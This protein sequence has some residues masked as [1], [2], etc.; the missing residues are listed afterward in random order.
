[1]LFWRKLLFYLFVAAYLVVCPLLILYT[2]G[3]SLRPGGE[4]TIVRTGMIYVSSIPVG[5]ELYL[6]GRL[7]PDRTP[8]A[9]RNLTPGTYEVRVAAPGY[10]SW[11]TRVTLRAN[12]VRWFNRVL[13]LPEVWSAVKRSEA[14]FQDLIPAEDAPFCI[15]KRGGTVGDYRIYLMQRDQLLPLSAAGTAL[16]DAEVRKVYTVDRSRSFLLE[17][18]GAGKPRVL[19]ASIHAEAVRLEDITAL[20]PA[21]FARVDWDPHDDSVLFPV[22]GKTIGMVDLE[23]RSTL[24][25]FVRQAQGAGVFERHLYVLST[26]RLLYRLAYP[27]GTRQPVADVPATGLTGTDQFYRIR[28]LAHRQVCLLGAQGQF[29]ALLPPDHA[30]LTGVR[31]FTWEPLRGRM[32]VWTR[33]RVG[34]LEFVPASRRASGEPPT[35]LRWVYSGGADVAQAFWVFRFS[36]VLVRDGTSLWLVPLGEEDPSPS[37]LVTCKKGTGVQYDRSTGTL[38]YIGATGALMSLE[39]V[40]RSELLKLSILE[41]RNEL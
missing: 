41:I 37:P 12:Q 1:M 39:I 15:L 8:T 33:E 11:S 20:L 13:L 32:L 27:D 40:P 17:V 29:L 6:Q 35:R 18:A 30:A 3:I 25:V 38:F 7:Q 24:P 26:E 16:A 9:V 10:R 14:P 19:Q 23:D 2:L 31:G 5:A 34:V 4:R 28:P 21:G 36:H 22:S